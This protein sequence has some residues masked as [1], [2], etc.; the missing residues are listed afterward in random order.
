MGVSQPKRIKLEINEVKGIRGVKFFFLKVSDRNFNPF[1]DT[2]F[3]SGMMWRRSKFGVIDQLGIGWSD[4][5][6]VIAKK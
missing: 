2:V 5:W 3:G 6:G 4:F 1:T